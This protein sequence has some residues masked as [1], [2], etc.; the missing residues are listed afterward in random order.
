[1]GVKAQG[2]NILIENNE[3]AYNNTAGFS[4]GH[5]AEAGGTKFTRTDDLVVRGNFAHH[6]RGVGLW[7]DINNINCLYENNRVEDNDWRGIFHEISYAC[8]IRNNIVRRNGFNSPGVSAFE[9]AGILISNSPNVQVYGNTVEA[10]NVGIMGIEANRESD[11]P[12]AYGPHNITNLFVHDNTVEQTNGGRAGGI[13]D[14]DSGANPYS[15]SANN[16]WARNTYLIGTGTKW[17]WAPN[18]D[19]LRSQWLAT[20]QDAGASVTE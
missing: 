8:I 5:Y 15:A 9:G 13:V 10:N 11:H 17:R 12:S 3:I 2:S 16:R 1:M 7:T 14:W 20:G 6:N 19:L 4:A 18:V